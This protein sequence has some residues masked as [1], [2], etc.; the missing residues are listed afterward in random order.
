MHL[1]RN[2]ILIRDFTLDDLPLMLRWLTNPIVLEFYG[3]RDIHYTME[4]LAADY[5]VA[6]P[7]G[8]RIIFEYDGIPI[9]YGQIYRVTETLNNGYG[10]PVAG[11]TVY[12]MD[13]FIGEPR[14]WS[15]GIGTTYLRTIT[16]YLKTHLKADAILVD[17][18]KSNPRAI[19][20]Y[21]KSGFRI[22]KSLPS[23]ELFEGKKEDCWLMELIP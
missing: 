23:F 9:G 21:E 13:Q 2:N 20:A 3:G 11:R 5:P 12:A 1:L 10:Y 22:I 7:D 17:P 19:R 6:I 14:Y 15:K 4:T 16:D 18:H 8:F